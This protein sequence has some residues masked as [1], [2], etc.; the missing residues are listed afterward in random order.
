MY[1]YHSVCNNLKF[2]FRIYLLHAMKTS[3]PDNNLLD[4]V[5]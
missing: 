3:G 2:I 5:Y 1:N 4:V